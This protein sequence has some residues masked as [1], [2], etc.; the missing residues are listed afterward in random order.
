MSAFN[1][2]VR[3]HSVLV[4]LTDRVEIL[5]DFADA[6]RDKKPVSPTEYSKNTILE[7]LNIT[8]ILMSSQTRSEAL[9]SEADRLVT[10]SFAVYDDG[11][12]MAFAQDNYVRAVGHFTP[13]LSTE[14]LCARVRKLSPEITKQASA[15]LRV[16][17]SYVKLFYGPTA[18]MFNVTDA[19]QY[20]DRLNEFDPNLAILQFVSLSKVSKQLN[21]FTDT[22]LR[23]LVASVEVNLPRVSHNAQPRKQTVWQRLRLITKQPKQST[24]TL[25]K[26]R[27][28][29]VLQKYLGIA[30]E[31]HTDKHKKYVL[32][33]LPPQT[34]LVFVLDDKLAHKF[35]NIQDLRA[36][37]GQ[38]AKA[39]R[40]CRYVLRCGDFTDQGYHRSR[41]IPHPAVC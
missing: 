11:Q 20:I 29:S 21:A 33:N 30:L 39:A 38:A 23:R 9:K 25:P 36:G 4:D 26:Q 31:L 6:V 8:K 41:R 17:C 3:R 18:G 5:A 16:C 32:D 35:P 10:D 13:F 40:Q 2:K 24:T 15:L 14:E 22:D 7:Y 34:P 28:A 19:D 37:G 1:R 27:V 12:R